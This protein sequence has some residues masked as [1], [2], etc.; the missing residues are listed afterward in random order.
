MTGVMN[1]QA[2]FFRMK[3]IYVYEKKGGVFMR[4]LKTVDTKEFYER[5]DFIYTYLKEKYG[6]SWHLGNNKRMY[7]RYKE[8]ID[9]YEKKK[10][11]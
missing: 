7:D 4:K 8:A 1:H 11:S 9:E 2:L 6:E 5:C 10:R 3:N